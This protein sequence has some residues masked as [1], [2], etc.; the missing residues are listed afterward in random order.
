M[1]QQNPLGQ[2]PLLHPQ[3]QNQNQQMNQQ[4]AQ[5]NNQQY[6]QVQNQNQ[7]NPPASQNQILCFPNGQEIL[8]PG[9]LYCEQNLRRR[10]ICDDNSIAISNLMILLQLILAQLPL[11]FT[12]LQVVG[13]SN[14]YSIQFCEEKIIRPLI[15]ENTHV[16]EQII[17]NSYVVNSSTILSSKLKSYSIVAIALQLV[18]SVY[19]IC[20]NLVYFNNKYSY[21]NSIGSANIIYIC[22]IVLILITLILFLVATV[23]NYPRL[24]QY[25]YFANLINQLFICA[26]ICCSFIIGYQYMDAY[27]A[28]LYISMAPI[29]LL[30]ISTLIIK[31]IQ[32][33]QVKLLVLIGQIDKNEFSKL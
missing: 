20:L 23:K 3:Y 12:S 25:T 32:I 5:Q 1:Y 13:N 7:Y 11:R 21:I 8:H 18:T 29:I 2:E 15:T 14:I 17:R 31:Y 27:L 26:E 24:V 22:Q 19:L 10:N 28:N 16:N 30:L 4:F 33:N 6:L 9:L